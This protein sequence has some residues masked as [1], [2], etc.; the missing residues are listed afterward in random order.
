MHLL[1]L[2]GLLALALGAGI[3]LYLSL[4]KLLAGAEIGTRP[5]LLLAVLLVVIGA[6]FFGLGLIGELLAHGSNGPRADAQ[7]PVRDA[8]GLD[9]P[10]WAAAPGTPDR[11]ASPAGTP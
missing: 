10:C 4:E 9:R 5:L 2:P 8:I 3:G 7:P 1:G 6:Q 11:P